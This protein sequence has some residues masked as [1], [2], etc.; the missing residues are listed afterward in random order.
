MINSKFM[1][2][3]IPNRKS[4]QEEFLDSE[5]Y[6]GLKKEVAESMASVD[7]TETGES[8]RDIAPVFDYF[9]K[10]LSRNGFLEGQAEK[11]FWQT[12]A[13]KIK[14]NFET[15]YYMMRADIEN[16]DYDSA[17]QIMTQELS[18][19]VGRLS[20]TL[21]ADLSRKSVALIVFK[22]EFYKLFPD[23]KGLA[24]EKEEKM[25]NDQ[26]MKNGKRKKGNIW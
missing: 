4:V 20:H 19:I 15:I 18:K 9:E 3:E 1:S 6:A 5:K 2:L 23:F 11:L 21:Y 10:E 26:K 14:P 13:E 17:R 16:R 22:E 8:D 25:K 24:K 7:V 12:V